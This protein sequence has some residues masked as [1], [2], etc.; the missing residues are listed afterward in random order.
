MIYSTTATT[1]VGNYLRFNS[2]S[3]TNYSRLDLYGNGSA[4]GSNK[5]TNATGIYGPFSMST[6]QTVNTIHIMNGSNTTT[7][8]PVVGRAGASDNSTLQFCGTWRSTSAITSISIHCD[9]ANFL[10]G[11]VFTIYGI[12][13]A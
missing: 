5:S 12:K 4:V 11:S 7:F 1:S 10:S 8:K 9:G 6:V 2:D 13:A 3:G